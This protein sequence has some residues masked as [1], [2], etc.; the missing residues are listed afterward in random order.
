MGVGLSDPVSRTP[1]A[2][3]NLARASLD[4]CAELHIIMAYKCGRFAA[5]HTPIVVGI[6]AAARVIR[7][8][9]QDAHPH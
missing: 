3:D 5:L 2:L 1:P 6:N 4:R 9:L 7:L 8:C